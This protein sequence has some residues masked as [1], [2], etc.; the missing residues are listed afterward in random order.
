M[1]QR[2][3]SRAD[4][5]YQDDSSITPIPPSTATTTTAGPRS[6]TTTSSPGTTTINGLTTTTVNPRQAAPPAPPTLAVPST[7]QRNPSLRIRRLP[8]TPSVPQL[9]LQ[10][11]VNRPT[12]ENVESASRRRSNSAPQRPQLS[13]YPPNDL[14]IRR[15]MTASSYLPALQEETSG[16]EMPQLLAVPSNQQPGRMRRASAVAWSMLTGQNTNNDTNAQAGPSQ[17]YDSRIIDM[18]DV[19]GES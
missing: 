6:T 1:D 19:I 2:R 12:D 9:R 11:D 3:S 18:L 4:R 8:S 13:A 7:V 5:S 17:E 10:G 14:D 16:H 15:Q